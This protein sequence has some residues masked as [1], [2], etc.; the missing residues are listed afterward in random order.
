METSIKDLLSKS[1]SNRLV[2]FEAKTE[3]LDL[4]TMEVETLIMALA[5]NHGDVQAATQDVWKIT[6]QIDVETP[7]MPWTETPEKIARTLEG[8]AKQFPKQINAYTIYLNSKE[9]EDDATLDA[10]KAALA[11]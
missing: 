6:T 2:E 4:L 11:E 10:I 9:Q 8:I 1:I 3:F 5:Y 7:K